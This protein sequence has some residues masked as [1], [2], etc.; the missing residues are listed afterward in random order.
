MKRRLVIFSVALMLTVGAGFSFSGS[1]KTFT[2]D[3]DGSEDYVTIQNVIDSEK[4]SDGDVIEVRSGTYGSN[5]G[6]WGI[7]VSKSVTLKAAEGEN[8]VL[9][10]QGK[11]SAIKISAP[12]VKLDGF[13]IIG[14]GTTYNGISIVANSDSE[15]E[16]FRNITIS[17]NEI[18]GI[19]GWWD[20]NN[21]RPWSYGILAAWGGPEG[22]IVIEGN[23]IY[24]IGGSNGVDPVGFGIVV[25]NPTDSEDKDEIGG[26][27]IIRNNYC[28][29]IYDGTGTGP[30]GFLG[31]A[32]NVGSIGKT[33]KAEYVLIEN[34]RYENVTNGVG[35]WAINSRVN[36][37]RSDFS[38]VPSLVI[39]MYEMTGIEKERLAPFVSSDKTSI[40]GSSAEVYTSN[41]ATA[42][43]FSEPGATI[44]F[45]PGTFPGTVITKPATVQS[46]DG[47]GGTEIKNL[48]TIG[49]SGVTFGGEK[50]KGLTFNDIK[51]LKGK[52]SVSWNFIKGKLTHEGAERLYAQLNY[53]NTSNPDWSARLA[54][55][56]PV[57]VSPWLEK[58]PWKSPSTLIVDK[59]GTKPSDGYLN[60]AVSLANEVS[61]KQIIKV[62]H[63][64][65][66]LSEAIGGKL[67]LLSQN[68]SPDDNFLSGQITIDG[69]NVQLGDWGEKTSRGFTVKSDITVNKGVDGETVSINWNNLRGDVIHK[70]SNTLDAGYNWWGDSNPKDDTVGNVDAKP[71]L[72]GPVK[73]LK[74]YMEE[75][76]I[77]DPKVALAS[78]TMK[79]SGSTQ[80]ATATAVASGV[81]FQ[82]ANKLVEDYGSIAVQEA[83][84]DAET[85]EELIQEL[86]RWKS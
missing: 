61:G 31:S 43:G 20:D 76:D 78:M 52:S 66:E 55:E 58:P 53:W 23:E 25:V 44:T 70:G 9:D 85:E 42:L 48:I 46:L 63:E 28:H 60:N 81:N 77:N 4:V 27:A 82:A 18:H 11:A 51:S 54:G 67:S 8:P 64:N 12:D 38:N 47:A 71:C 10:G 32:I 22:E 24:D 74:K 40:F 26:G 49:R 1:A 37:D 80:Q 62:R 83:M 65:S 33:T 30:R 5:P 36:E 56:G 57:I 16:E 50:G 17:N 69:S 72:P 41:L 39:N 14:N 6:L 21:D 86:E 34:N 84:E 13:E 7:D 2:V 35:V 75:N 15:E 19:S 45:S 59:A 68:G 73:E 79:D 29:D 3:D